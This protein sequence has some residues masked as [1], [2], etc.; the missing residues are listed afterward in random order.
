M[1]SIPKQTQ[2]LVVGGGPSGSYSAGVLAREGFDVVL[3]ESTKHPRYHIGE[4]LLPSVRPHLRFFGVEE[5]VRDHGFTQKPGAVAHFVK[6]LPPAYTNF[7]EESK[8]NGVWNVERA[9]FDE[10]LLRQAQALGAKVFEDVKVT[11]LTFDKENPAKPVSAT[12]TKKGDTTAQTITFDYLV[13]ASGRFGLMSTKYLKNRRFL[14]SLKNYANWAYFEGQNAYAP[15]GTDRENAPYFQS[16]AD[17]TGWVW[18]IPLQGKVSVGL[19]QNEVAFKKIRKEFASTEEYYTA[20]LKGAPQVMELLGTA[21]RIASEPLR[22]ASDFSYRSKSWAK[23]RV[24][25]D[26]ACFID[27]LFSSGVHMALTG[28]LSAATT[29]AASIRK[30]CTEEQAAKYHD[31]KVSTAF[32]RFLIVVLGVYVQIKRQDV[33]V[34]ATEVCKSCVWNGLLMLALELP[35]CH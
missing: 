26:A 28:G 35:T 24:V 12:Y 25:G 30:N 21:T 20:G 34:T 1:A 29:I 17:G 11:E 16:L 27:P 6:D 13:D 8:D 31:K 15:V 33:R 9:Q 5:K 14:D 2:I 7:I 3:L 10:I 4:S 23:L 32:A 18:F 22:S 19:V